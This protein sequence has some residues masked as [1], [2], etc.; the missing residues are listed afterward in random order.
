LSAEPRAAR[1]PEDEL[2]LARAAAYI[3]ADSAGLSDDQVRALADP[4]LCGPVA[5]DRD[6]RALTAYR[7]LGSGRGGPYLQVE[8]DHA[9]RTVTVHAG[10]HHEERPP[11]IYTIDDLQG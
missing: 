2:A 5:I 3:F 11:G 10:D 7:W 8:I 9:A 6:D 4:P 1:S